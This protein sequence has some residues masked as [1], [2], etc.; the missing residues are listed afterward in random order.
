V[1]VT[2]ATYH[3]QFGGFL[4]LPGKFFNHGRLTAACFSGNECHAP[5]P[6]SKVEIAVSWSSSLHATKTVFLIFC[7]CII[8]ETGR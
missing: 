7:S 1:C 8:K 2:I 3:D 4:R 6:A 5:F